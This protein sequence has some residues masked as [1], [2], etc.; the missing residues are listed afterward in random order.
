M[1]SM[2]VQRLHQITL[3]AATPD[4]LWQRVEAVWS[5]VPQEHIQSLFESMP[6]RVVAVVISNNA[7]TLATDSGRNHT[8][9]KSINLTI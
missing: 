8:S 1:W 7:A 3:Q 2:V 6:R 9:Q 5:A 4:R